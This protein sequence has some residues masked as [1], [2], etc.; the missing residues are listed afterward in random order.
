MVTAKHHSG[1]NIVR[2][3]RWIFRMERDSI[4]KFAISLGLGGRRNRATLEPLIV[5]H[6][7][8]GSIIISNH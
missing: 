3:Q 8:P 6:I 4:K 1:K 5:K 2:E 7:K